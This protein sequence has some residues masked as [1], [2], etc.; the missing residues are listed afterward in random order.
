MSE[1]L[2]STN[3]EMVEGFVNS[4]YYQIMLTEKYAK[5]FSKQL[6]EKYNL[7]ITLE[8]LTALSI[9]S[10]HN[11]EIHQRKLAQIILKDRANTGRMLKHLEQQELISREEQTKNKRQ[12]FVL[13]ITDKGLSMI[14]LFVLY[15]Y[16]QDNAI[17]YILYHGM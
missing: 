8:E 7:P 17:L 1:V 4:L 11:G 10:Q 9:V 16:N 14:N 15:H 6:E 2:V 12:V 5:V 13:T 3:N